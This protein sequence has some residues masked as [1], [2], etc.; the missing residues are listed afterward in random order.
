MGWWIPTP[1]MSLWLY[2][3]TSLLFNIGSQ[4]PIDFCSTVNYSGNK[5]FKRVGIVWGSI[6]LL[7]E[8]KPVNTK[9]WLTQ[10][11]HV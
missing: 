5:I 4:L 1:R 6:Y 3:E 8:S 2:S 11:L 9:Y 7:S 10:E